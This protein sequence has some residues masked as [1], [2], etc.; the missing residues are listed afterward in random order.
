MAVDIHE[1]EKIISTKSVEHAI[2]YLME[3]HYWSRTQATGFIQEL[4]HG[5]KK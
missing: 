4:L 3:E 2:K 5:K 1:L